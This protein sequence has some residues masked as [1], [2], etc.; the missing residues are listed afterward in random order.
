[1]R[2][3]LPLHEVQRAVFE[4][5]RGRTDIAIFGAQAVNVHVGVSRMTEDVDLLSSS[6]EAIANELAE[7]LHRAFHAAI[8]VRAVRPGQG[9]RIY[10]ARGEESRHLVDVRLLEFPLRYLELDG[11]RYVALQQLAAM[12]MCALVR[13]RLAPKG[14]TDLADLRRLLLGHPELIADPSTVQ[15]A[16]GEVGGGDEARAAW[17]EL[18]AAPLVPD[19]DGDGY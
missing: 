2:E 16:I 18:V 1:M 19:D 17:A 4:F 10:Q 11:V 14:A 7:A 12:K 9:Y 6:P 8:R 5:C 3:P 13:R 15:A